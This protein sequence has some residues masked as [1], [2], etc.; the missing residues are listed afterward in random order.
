MTGA[1]LPTSSEQA[2]AT[3][4]RPVGH[5]AAG[6]HPCERCVLPDC[7]ITARQCQLRLLYRTYK[8]K[9]DHHQLDAITRDERIA[10]RE[11]FNEWQNERLAQ[12]A[13]GVRPFRHARSAWQPGKPAPGGAS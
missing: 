5:G 7:E 9:V 4:R 2:P 11:Y 3:A 1:A 6:K 12:A 13:E 10:S 8:H